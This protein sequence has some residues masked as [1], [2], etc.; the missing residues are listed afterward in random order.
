MPL[1]CQFEEDAFQQQ[2][3]IAIG[4]T[5]NI[6]T[7]GGRRTENILGYD[8]AFY[9]NKDLRFLLDQRLY[10]RPSRVNRRWIGITVND[11]VW[12]DL[13]KIP[14][15]KIP[16]FKL[17]LF[18]Q[19]KVPRKM[20]GHVAPEWDKWKEPYFRFDVR[21]PQHE[22]MMRINDAPNPPLVCYA[23]PA[24]ND[25]ATL[26]R[27]TQAGDVL[28]HS[29]FVRVGKLKGHERYTYLNATS[30]GIGHSEAEDI[31]NERWSEIL[32]SRLEIA[33]E[34]TLEE[35]LNSAL[36]NIT[37]AVTGS[38]DIETSFKAILAATPGAISEIERTLY[39]IDAFESYFR[40]KLMILG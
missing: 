32:R 20:V 21:H 23:A 4:K 8:A 10:V 24:F 6:S 33:E 34:K 27:V 22:I 1:E 39:I 7:T 19:S 5:T 15:F 26:W 40:I 14:G 9:V 11:K 13:D 3:D 30:I 25:A 37:N 38:T 36:E 17:N 35:L 12:T 18:I 28:D 16:P 31:E 29:H 2:I